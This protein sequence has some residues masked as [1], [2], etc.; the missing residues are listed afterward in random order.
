MGGTKHWRLVWQCKE[1]SNKTP[2]WISKPGL[3]NESWHPP[4]PLTAAPPCSSHN[5]GDSGA[6]D[7]TRAQ[8]RTHVDV[9]IRGLHV[10]ARWRRTYP[11]ARRKSRGP[12]GEVNP[13]FTP[14]PPGGFISAPP[15]PTTTTTTIATNTV[16]TP[17]RLFRS[18]S[19]SHR[20]QLTYIPLKITRPL[21]TGGGV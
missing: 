14:P 15:S 8:Q 16:T 3:T 21:E 17:S 5:G 11:R 6:C 9:G 12:G 18:N 7:V 19:L 1:N 10:Y 2:P 13:Y 4:S 20:P